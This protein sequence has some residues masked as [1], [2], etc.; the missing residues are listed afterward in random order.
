MRTILVV[1]GLLACLA[2]ALAAGVTTKPGPQIN[3]PPPQY[4]TKPLPQAVLQSLAGAITRDEQLQMIRTVPRMGELLKKLAIG[5]ALYPTTAGGSWST[6]ITLTPLSLVYPAGVQKDE[7]CQLLLYSEAAVFSP[8]KM[9]LPAPGQNPPLLWL[10]RCQENPDLLTLK[11]RYPEPGTYLVTFFMRD[12]STSSTGEPF[13]LVDFR[14]V[15]VATNAT[16]DRW[17]ILHSL[18]TLPTGGT[19]WVTVRP[20]SGFN[21]CCMSKVVV[22]RLY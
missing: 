16:R 5:K 20:R 8:P 4:L 3:P 13:I 7:D 9:M 1:G 21:S 10:R 19:S 18:P 12:N 17:T 14:G 15:D 22:S 2:M 11:T 6:G